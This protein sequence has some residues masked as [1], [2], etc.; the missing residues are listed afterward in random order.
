M[1]RDDDLKKEAE[2]MQTYSEEQTGTE[3]NSNIHYT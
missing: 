3:K 1:M 2:S